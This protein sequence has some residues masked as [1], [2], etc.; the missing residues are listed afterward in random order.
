MIST[1]LMKEGGISF[2]DF[3]VLAGS[4]SPGNLIVQDTITVGNTVSIL[5]THDAVSIGTGALIVSGGVSVAASMQIGGL[6]RV[7]AS[8]A[9]TN[10]ET[11]ALVVTGG[12]GIQ[13]DLNVRGAINLGG[14]F[15]DKVTTVTLQADQRTPSDPI[16]GTGTYGCFVIS[17]K[18]DRPEGGAT[19][20]F[21]ASGGVTKHGSVFRA[22]STPGP[23]NETLTMIY[24]DEPRLMWLTP[25]SDPVG[26][27]TFAVRVSRL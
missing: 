18:H 11:G 23:L 26:E 16:P 21:M 3:A 13:G 6:L 27:Y 15:L 2:G 22:T 19:A 17:V 5:A 12:V 25:P 8:T 14:M 20:I 1:S 4:W 10:P 9:S 24:A 7:T